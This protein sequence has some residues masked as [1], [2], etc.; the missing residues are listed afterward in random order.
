[1]NKTNYENVIVI[2]ADLGEM[3]AFNIKKHEG[4]VEKKLK[5]SYSLEALSY[6]NYIDPHLSVRNVTR[7]SAGR[8]GSSKDHVGVGVG[9]S[10]G[11]IPEDHNLENERKRRSIEDVANDINLI[12]KN[13]KPKQLWL[14]FPQESNIQL[15]DQL[16]K[17]TKDVL[18][19]N[20]TS[21]L[22][23]IETAKILSHF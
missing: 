23:N 17:E 1:M 4:M 9:N 7:D 2:V 12:V 18:V 14:A 13:E 11:S 20:V 6:I 10:I 3:K 15:L 16:S 5:I 21:D 22:I 19:K 8:F